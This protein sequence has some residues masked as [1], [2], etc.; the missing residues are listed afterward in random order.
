MKKLLTSWR[1]AL[2]LG[3]FMSPVAAECPLEEGEEQFPPPPQSDGPD[4]VVTYLSYDGANYVFKGIV[5]NQGT[6]STPSGVAIISNFYVDGVLVTTGTVAGPLAMGKS[7]IIDS[8]GGVPY[9]M[10]AAKHVYTTGVNEGALFEELDAGN[11]TF[12]RNYP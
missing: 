10:P 9:E 2:C 3:L 1:L 7:V 11:N 8:S 12:S 6:G 5:K 4:L